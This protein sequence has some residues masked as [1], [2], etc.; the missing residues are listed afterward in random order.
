MTIQRAAINKTKALFPLKHLHDTQ[1]GE[2]W[3]HYLLARLTGTPWMSACLQELIMGKSAFFVVFRSPMMVVVVINFKGNK[4]REP[5]QTGHFLAGF[6]PGA[7]GRNA[8]HS[9]PQ[10]GAQSGFP[11]W[12][13]VGQPPKPSIPR[14][15]LET[16]HR[17]PTMNEAA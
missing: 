3:Q 4:R 7:E 15:K 1:W 10:T 8:R 12:K 9:S 11:L 5:F 13:V 2:A 6:L 14:N 17:A 16:L